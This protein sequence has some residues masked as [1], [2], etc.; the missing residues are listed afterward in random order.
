MKIKKIFRSQKG[1]AIILLSVLVTGIVMLISAIAVENLK[2][3]SQLQNL[4]R[5]SVNELY[6]AEEGI[7]FALYANKEKIFVGPASNSPFSVSVWEN[8]IKNTGTQALN[9]LS[10][11]TQGKNIVISS[12]NN[13]DSSTY[14]NLKR[15]VF[16][17]LPSRYYDQLSL[18]DFTNGCGSENC[19]ITDNNNDMQSGH[20]YQAV[21]STS[22]FQKSGWTSDNTQYRVVFRCTSSDC[23]IKNLRVGT[24]ECNFTQC[25]L[26]GC[27][28]LMD[29]NFW[30]ESND[31][32]GSV[33]VSDWFQYRD[34]DYKLIDLRNGK[35]LV[36]FEIVSGNLAEASGLAGNDIKMCKQNSDGIWQA[37]TDRLGGTTNLEIR[38]MGKIDYN[39]C[40]YSQICTR[41]KQVCAKYEQICD[42]QTDTNCS[43]CQS[44]PSICDLIKPYI[45]WFDGP[46][47]IEWKNG[48]ECEQS[49]FGKCNRYCRN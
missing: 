31:M 3:A 36:Y 49:G 28:S 5:N 4:Q 44:T 13:P 46:N 17:N 19:N 11:L 9:K 35:L 14:G 47:C 39:C 29:I 22:D 21:L 7:E 45:R 15:T 8:N 18:W 34:A 27:S 26:S 32:S 33:I 10:Q 30:N 25:P 38:K 12:E 41:Y 42:P 48:D 24:G 2:K 16:A 1:D 23:E 37:L 6:K 43:L 40:G 20:A